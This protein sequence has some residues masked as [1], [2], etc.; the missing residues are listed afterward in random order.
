MSDDV[1]ISDWQ[2]E[3]L[4]R[5]KESQD[6]VRKAVRDIISELNFMGNEKLV[7]EA[8]KEELSC[9]HR[10]LQQGFFGDVLVPV[11]RQYAQFKKDGWVDL[12]N[13]DACDCATKLEPILKDSYFRFI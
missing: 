7:G 3:K 11:I 10:T 12:R 4:M 2:I 13:E 1:E 8:V 5:D 9:T 6:K